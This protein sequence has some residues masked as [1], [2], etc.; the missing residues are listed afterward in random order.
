[1]KKKEKSTKYIYVTIGVLILIY[2]FYQIFQS[3]YNPIKTSLAQETEIYDSV[4]VEAVII[5]DEEVIKSSKSGT[6]FACVQDGE[7]VQTGGTI[8]KVFSSDSEAKSYIELVEIEKKISYYENILMQSSYETTSLDVVDNSILGNVNDYIR[9]INYGWLENAESESGALIDNITNRKIIIGEEIDVNSVLNELYTQRTNLNKSVTSSETIVSEYAG[10]FVNYVDGNEGKVDFSKASELS[11]SNIENILNEQ[12]N[13]DNSSAVGKVIKSFDWYVACVVDKSKVSEL[14]KGDEVSVNFNNASVGELKAK[15]SSMNVDTD[16]ANKIAIIL[17][18]DIMNEKTAKIHGNKVDIRF[19]SYKGIKVSNN[20]LR[21]VTIEEDGK[22][23]TV[24]CVYV[25][26]GNVVRRKLVDVIYTGDDFVIA[27]SNSSSN[28][29]IR[30]YDK[31][32]EK[33]KDLY[34]GKI[35]RYKD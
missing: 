6:M 31:V 14:E 26:S 25:L 9:T 13:T 32:I 4:S 27:N 11:V 2:A 19:N 10:Y 1:M 29:Y 35:V 28:G 17:K 24:K 12:K 5:R 34:D 16:N 30:L 20:A 7:R 3:T 18:L 8:A 21:A 23:K 22:E 15:V 33:G